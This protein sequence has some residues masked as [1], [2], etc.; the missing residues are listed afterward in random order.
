MDLL[1]FLVHWVLYSLPTVVALFLF[2]QDSTSF[3]SGTVRIPWVEAPGVT[4]RTQDT[5]HARRKEK[6]R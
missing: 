6:P 5:M 1:M 3:V 2:P 4:K